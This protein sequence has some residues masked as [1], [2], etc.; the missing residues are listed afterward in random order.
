M[1]AIPHLGN[2][3]DHLVVAQS[4]TH[5]TCQAP[6]SQAPYYGRIYKT[7]DQ[8]IPNDSGDHKL[9][10]FAYGMLSPFDGASSDFDLSDG[11]WTCP[12]TGVYR[13]CA[14]ARL[15]KSDDLLYRF[16]L[17]LRVSL[18][19]FYSN[20]DFAVRIFQIRKTDSDDFQYLS[21]EINDLL[22]FDK[23]S[24]VHLF[25]KGETASGTSTITGGSNL[26]FMAVE[27][28]A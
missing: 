13:I 28:V 2:A 4:G 7:V 10:N 1:H 20:T 11:S 5:A 6:S 14:A 24:V 23:D 16:V 8:T 15:A 17:R 12:Q 9:T 22:V 21:L 27:R 18:V 3:G 19:G 26:T 25:V